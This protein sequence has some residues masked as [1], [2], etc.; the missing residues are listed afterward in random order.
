VSIP[1]SRRKWI[2]PTTTCPI[3]QE[4]SVKVC[5]SVPC[6]LINILL[7]AIKYEGSQKS[8]VGQT[9]ESPGSHNERMLKRSK[10]TCLS[11]CLSVCQEA[12]ALKYLSDF[13]ANIKTNLFGQKLKNRSVFSSAHFNSLSSVQRLDSS[14]EG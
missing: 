13:H 12:K 5:V 2:L 8:R 10:S 9:A 6:Q 4:Y 3:G 1:A 11:V 7:R 14:T